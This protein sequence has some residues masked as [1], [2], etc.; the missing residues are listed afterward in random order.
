MG[1]SR[2]NIVLQKVPEIEMDSTLKV[3]IIGEAEF[4]RGLFYFNLVRLF[5]DI[6]LSLV[7]LSND[8]TDEEVNMS[9][10]PKDMIFNQII[11]DLTN[12]SQKCPKIYFQGVDKG[13][14]T[15][16]AALSLLANVHLTIGNWE[17]ASTAANEVMELGVYGLYPDY[18]SNFKDIKRNG[19]ESV[20]A[21]QFY[22]GVP[23]QQNQIVISGLPTIPGVFPA[24]VEIMLPTEDLLNSFEEGDYRHEVTFFDQYWYDTFDPHIWKH[25]DQDT[26]EPDKTSQCGSNFAIIRYSEILLIYAEAQNELSGPNSAAYDAINEV[27]A[28]ARNG[29]EDILPDLAGLSKDD[30][31]EAVLKERRVEF[32]N[33]GKRWYDLI[34]TNNLIE[35]VVRAKGN[36]ANPQ[37][38]NHVFP[39]PQRRNGHQ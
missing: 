28:R 15:K 20:F 21:A 11:E 4:L 5:G 27:R 38:Y 18:S 8:L 14:A 6:P 3:Q 16:G 26:Y 23:S 1:I 29:N 25:W 7:P 13:R 36:I 10:T 35:Y 33:E 34:R 9:R 19:M 37:S 2:A 22:S 24:G 30:F 17:E 31:R 32:V 12:A 39:I